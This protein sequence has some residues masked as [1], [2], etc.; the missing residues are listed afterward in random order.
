MMMKTGMAI[1]D[2][3][4][5]EEGDGSGDNGTAVA[6]HLSIPGMEFM[7]IVKTGTTTDDNEGG[8]EGDGSR[9]EI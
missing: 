9:Q 7:M 8:G 5:N 3:K 2:G 1:D 4:G 6:E